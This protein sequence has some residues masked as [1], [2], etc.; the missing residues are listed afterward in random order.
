MEIFGRRVT[1]TESVREKWGAASQLANHYR[2]RGFAWKSRGR[3]NNF[4]APA[5]SQLVDPV[6]FCLPECEGFNE[7]AQVWGMLV[8][9]IAAI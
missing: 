2:M 7:E 4:P 6:P 9:V 5:R 1:R 8:P 3:L